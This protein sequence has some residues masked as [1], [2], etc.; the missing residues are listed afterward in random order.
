MPDHVHAMLSVPVDTG[1]KKPIINWKSYTART[2]GIQWQ[3]D[4]FDHRI[5]NY[6]EYVEKCSYILSNPV[7]AGLCS[8][9]EYWPYVIRHTKKLLD[10]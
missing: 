4:F 8:A 9:N 3:R 6:N 10:V 5:R 2:L 1:L 7:R